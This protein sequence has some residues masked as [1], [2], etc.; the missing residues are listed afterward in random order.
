MTRG[1]RRA[2]L[3]A[4]AVALG[5]LLAGCAGRRARETTTPPAPAPESAPAPGE[6][7]P[8]GAGVIHVVR[9]GETLWRIARTYGVPLDDLARENGIADPTRIEIGQ[10]IFV[11]GA[12]T[13]LEVPPLE[14]DRP[15]PGLEPED[16]ALPLLEGPWIWPVEGPVSSRFGEPRGASRHA[17]IDI[18]TEEGTRVRAAR[19]GVVVFSGTRGA[20]GRLVIIDHGEGYAT[21]Y[22]HNRENHVS[23][24]ERVRQG[25]VIGRA[26]RSGNASGVHLHF[27]IRRKGRALDPMLFLPAR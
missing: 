21:W 11:K 18:S 17:G 20:Y 14:P 12:R 26:G 8:R 2:V 5:V 22:A 24:G 7:S 15:E 4:S 27:E 9:A 6:P 3:V 25:D 23:A 10:P 1:V 16:E 13:V 19:D